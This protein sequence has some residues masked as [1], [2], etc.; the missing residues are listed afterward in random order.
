MKALCCLACLLTLWASACSLELPQAQEPAPEF[1]CAQDENCPTGQICEVGFC[2]APAQPDRAISIQLTPPNTTDFVTNQY[3]NVELRQ[4]EP[5]PDLELQ[6]PWLMLGEVKLVGEQEQP[7]AAR[8]VLR[9]SSGS[10]PGRLQRYETRSTRERGYSLQVADGEY[11]I[12]VLPE[13]D[14][15]PPVR[16]RSFPVRA[17]LQQDFVLDLPE[18]N[19]QVT[20]RVLLSDEA[21]SPV[22]QVRVS[23][24]D[25]DNERVSGLA[26]TD[27]QGR[28]V[29]PVR[30]DVQ[31]TRLL[32]EPQDESTALP[33]VIVEDIQLAGQ[34]INLGDLSL[35]VEAA[36]GQ[37]AA[38]LVRGEQGTLVAG[39]TVIAQGDIGAGQLTRSAVTSDEGYFEM[40]LAPGSYTVLV[41]PP[42]S[43]PFAVTER[44]NQVVP[45]EGAATDFDTLL[46]GRK[47]S[48]S[49]S[50]LTQGGEP[51]VDAVFTWRATRLWSVRRLEV[52]RTY[53][54]RTDAQGQLSLLA[55]PGL[56]D[57]EVA[58]AP[59]SGWPHFW[60]RQVEVG[61]QGASLRLSPLPSRLAYGT[62]ISADGA[63]MA[64]VQV[65]IFMLEGSGE[66]TLLGQGSTN[67][68]GAYRVVL[69]AEP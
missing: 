49:G 17:D 26:L 11:D 2:V 22:P 18:R 34:E 58:P 37:Q 50:L 60:R 7:L 39:A 52:A 1:Y 32:L 23:A 21:G 35:G 44:L 6:R 14:D 54:A 8:L 30:L 5:L 16:L 61:D 68:D 36:R 63:V 46:L 48:V 59:S 66:A 55:E 27:A 24:L 33:R 41:I 65:D 9:R 42:E 51:V 45:A 13:R 28:F 57:I 25:E 20:G 47:P 40:T 12:L 10:I 62:V 38:G 64:D 56:Y 67:E 43:S 53:T 31:Q 4:G 29:L 19:I 69:P 15:L 3:I